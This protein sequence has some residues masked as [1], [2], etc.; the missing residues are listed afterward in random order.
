MDAAE[1]DHIGIG[2][3]R[4]VGEAEG[5]ADVIREVLNL[6]DLVVVGEDDG[7]PCFARNSLRGRAR[8]WNT[9]AG[10]RTGVRVEARTKTD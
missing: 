5:V 8:T 10:P 7:V 6:A 9:S 1:T 2:F 4:L 3:L